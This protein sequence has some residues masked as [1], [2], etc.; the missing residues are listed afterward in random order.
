[1]ALTG[2]SFCMSAI[3]AFILSLKHKGTFFVAKG[4]GKV[5]Q[6]V[7]RLF[8]TIVNTGIGYGV[9]SMVPSFKEDI[10]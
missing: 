8:I 4:V 7:G 3:Q 2:E 9:I 10:D 1:M 5:I 6:W